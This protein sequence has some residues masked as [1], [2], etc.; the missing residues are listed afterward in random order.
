ME[1]LLQYLD[2]L[3]DILYAM[4]LLAEQFRRAIKRIFLL[5]GSISL[6]FA[7]ILL[8]LY[9]PPLASAVAALLLVGLLYRAAVVPVPRKLAPQ[10]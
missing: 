6:Q 1:R 3:E 4:P 8:A 9:H 7:G 10:A 5:L 2:D